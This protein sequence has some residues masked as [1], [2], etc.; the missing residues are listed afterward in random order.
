MYSG[1]IYCAISPSNKKYYGKTVRPFKRRIY[2][3]LKNSEVSI[4][5]FSTAIR[6][7]GINNFSWNIVETIE[8]DSRIKLR[9]L[10]NEREKYWIEKDKTYLREIGYNMTPGGDGGAA[11][12]RSLS[13]K[14]KD[15]IRNSLLGIKHTE[16][17]KRNESINSLGVSRGKGIPKSESHRKNMMKP[18]SEEAKKNM[19]K[20][21]SPEHVKN[22]SLAFKGRKAWNK[23][24]PM[25]EEAKKEMIKSS[26]GVSR[27]KGI[28]PWNKKERI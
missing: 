28:I 11:F 13:E 16:E 22:M 1:I 21:K 17:R 2:N 3:H 18:M 26:T 27:N 9:E 10:L 15:K 12:G 14:T 7:Y 24:I 20:P 5:H 4:C 25:S 23:G 6:K 8:A 19:R